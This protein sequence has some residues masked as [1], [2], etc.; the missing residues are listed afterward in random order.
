M[1]KGKEKNPLTGLEIAVV[2]MSGRFPEKTG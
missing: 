2:G 1:I